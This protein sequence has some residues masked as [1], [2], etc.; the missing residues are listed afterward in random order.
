MPK[1]NYYRMKGRDKKYKN[2]YG[3]KIWRLHRAIKLAKD[4]YCLFCEERGIKK[5]ANVVDH[6]I[7]I[8]VD[9]DKRVE[10]DNLRSLCKTCHD[11]LSN[12][13][14][15]SL[16]PRTFPDGSPNPEFKKMWNIYISQK[17]H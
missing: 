13:A 14:R 6:I 11:N 8:V 16:P 7:P 9:W 1:S 15:K 12:L 4:P 10:W 17:I 5:L 3:L 2:F